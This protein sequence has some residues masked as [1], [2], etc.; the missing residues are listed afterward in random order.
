MN[1]RKYIK[2]FHPDVMS[3]ERS[4]REF[5]RELCEFDAGSRFCN[6]NE[7]LVNDAADY[8]EAGKGVTHV[9]WNQIGERR[10]IVAYFTLTATSIPYISRTYYTDEEA[11]KYGEQYNDEIW[12]IPAIEIGMFAVD[13]KYQDLFFRID[14]YE[15]PISAYCLL[16]VIGF[17]M[18]VMKRTVGF[19][20]LFLHSVP[21]AEAFYERNGFRPVKPHW[22]PLKSIDSEYTAMY[23]ALQ[24]LDDYTEA[25]K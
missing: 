25:E 20:A 11:E 23:M 5:F 3:Y 12:G 10:E 6:F 14:D 21:T 24:E 8:A 22:Q 7:F 4:H 16:T 19:K 13:Q 18:R 17:A 15:A 2:E 9:I 1:S